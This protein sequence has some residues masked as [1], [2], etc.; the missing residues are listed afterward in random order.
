[1]EI[2]PLP[3]FSEPFSSWTH[4]LAAGTALLGGYVLF[5]RGRGNAL[6]IFSLL[7]FSFSLIFLF[8]MS[9]VYHLLEPGRAP[10]EVFMHLDHSA[11]F[12]LIAGT[13]TPIHIIL[14]R[15]PLRWGY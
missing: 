13:F 2:I 5:T 10:R 9:G 3:G 7:V 8:S 12:V 4:L 11:I 15:G 6:R 1:M 14:F